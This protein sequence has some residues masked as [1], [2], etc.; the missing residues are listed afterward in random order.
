MLVIVSY[1]PINAVI[2]MRG[3]QCD[4]SSLLPLPK[5]VPATEESVVT[6]GKY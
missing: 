6:P 1:I 2:E 3:P 4:S 5:V